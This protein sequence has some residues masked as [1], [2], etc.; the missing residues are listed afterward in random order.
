MSTL[1]LKTLIA[2]CIR[3]AREQ[4]WDGDAADFVFTREDLD[5]VVETLGKRPTRE[6]WREAGVAGWIGA[7]HV[8]DE[9]SASASTFVLV[10]GE[11]YITDTTEE[12]EAAKAALRDAGYASADVWAG[13]PADE[14]YKNGQILFA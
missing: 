8:S 14:S 10:D 3:T 12:I 5:S 13:D 11:A 1:T 6:E 2:D 4:G 7:A 9:V